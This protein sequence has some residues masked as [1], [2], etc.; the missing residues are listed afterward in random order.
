MSGDMAAR[1]PA[2]RI[3]T[4]AHRL[5]GVIV[6]FLFD[7]AEVTSLTRLETYQLATTVFTARM[8]LTH[9]LA[10]SEVLTDVM[11]DQLHFLAP[12]AALPQVTRAARYHRRL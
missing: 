2:T 3:V 5:P 11:N 1:I 4:H 6:G 9:W 7:I 8:Y 10:A 12:F